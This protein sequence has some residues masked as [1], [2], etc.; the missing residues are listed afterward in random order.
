MSHQSSLWMTY[1]IKL[2][3]TAECVPD[4]DVARRLA[5]RRTGWV[6]YIYT[7]TDCVSIRLESRQ[8]VT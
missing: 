2:L 7:Y 5:V 4:H 8:G 6:D 3:I 1:C